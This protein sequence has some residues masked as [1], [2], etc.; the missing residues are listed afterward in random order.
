MR[1]VGV[2]NRARWDEVGGRVVMMVGLPS[3]Q[4]GWPGASDVVPATP[5]SSTLSGCLVGGA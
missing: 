2:L 1:E 5:T 3:L 4:S